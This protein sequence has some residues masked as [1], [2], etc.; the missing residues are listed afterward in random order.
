M[1]AAVLRARGDV[2]VEDVPAP[3]LT[4]DGVLLRVRAAS[5]CNATDNHIVWAEDPTSVWPNKPYPSLLGHECVGE[6][7]EVGVHAGPFRP[8]DWLAFWGLDSGAFAEYVVVRP[9][10]LAWMITPQGMP[11]RAWPVSRWRSARHGCS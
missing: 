11:A 8:G 5:I 10:T 7:V 1:K 6:V 2:R 4:A 3:E 9:A